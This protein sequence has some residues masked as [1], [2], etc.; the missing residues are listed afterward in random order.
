MARVHVRQ[1]GPEINV[2][3]N[4]LRD[5]MVPTAKKSVYAQMKLPVIALPAFARVQQVGLDLSVT[6]AAQEVCMA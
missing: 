5:F 3:L 6:R 2:K 1:D 4:A